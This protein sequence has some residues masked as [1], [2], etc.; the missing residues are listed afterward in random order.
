MVAIGYSGYRSQEYVAS[1]GKCDSRKTQLSSWDTWCQLSLHAQPKNSPQVMHS[2]GC[3]QKFCILT[4]FWVF[5]TLKLREKTR[6]GIDHLKWCGTQNI[7]HIHVPRYFQTY[8][9]SLC[10]HF[11][12]PPSHRGTS[13]G[14]S[15][16]ATSVSWWYVSWQSDLILDCTVLADAFMRIV[17]CI[18]CYEYIYI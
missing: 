9:M 8:V 5:I 17:E 4:S 14:F 2:I 12:I 11:R 15:F 13:H 18:C 3:F 7:S 10:Q 6:H 1:E 16:W